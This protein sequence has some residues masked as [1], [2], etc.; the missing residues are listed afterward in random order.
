MEM[1]KTIINVI[2]SIFVLDVAVIGLWIVMVSGC[3]D[4][5]DSRGMIDRACGE[6]S[7]TEIVRWQFD[8]F[9]K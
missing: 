8:F 5:V 6:N 3:F 2:L 1:K 7:L 9:K 4:Y